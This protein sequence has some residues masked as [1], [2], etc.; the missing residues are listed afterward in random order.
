MKKL[1]KNGFFPL[2]AAAVFSLVLMCFATAWDLDIS[3]A[4]TEMRASSPF[5]FGFTYALQL[6]GEWPGPLFG[7]FAVAIII[8]NISLRTDK[9][10]ALA[11]RISGFALEY[12][13]MLYCV[14]A[15]LAGF[16]EYHA[17]YTVS[18]VMIPA[19]LA[20]L[21]TVL[22]QRINEDAL[23]RLYAPAIVTFF[24]ALAVLIVIQFMKM[25]WGR[26]RFREFSGDLS[27]FTPWYKIN[28]FSGHNSF[29]SGHT[30]NLAVILAFPVW[31][32]ALGKSRRRIVFSYVAISLCTV[33]M[34]L[35]R[36][37]I[38]AHFLSDV[39]VGFFIAFAATEAVRLI[40]NKVY[41][42]VG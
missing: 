42:K 14:R 23:T 17:A 39:T 36:I 41:K 3:V 30:A 7:S 35:S 24:A 10:R 1:L 27:L 15:T 38:G 34:A 13:L 21:I 6:I 4:A 37:F 25:L 32:R 8:R 22:T 40:M 19:S 31:L 9:K 18:C 16:S 11:W 29:P 33:L 28:F 5:L 26:V 2:A 12:I 20:L